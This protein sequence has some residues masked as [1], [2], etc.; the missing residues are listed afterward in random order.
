MKIDRKETGVATIMAAML[1]AAVSMYSAPI[2]FLSRALQLSEN[3]SRVVLFE[4]S[5][6]LYL[7]GLFLSKERQVRERSP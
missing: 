2:E 6:G 5:I 3:W 4:A 1:L 7:C